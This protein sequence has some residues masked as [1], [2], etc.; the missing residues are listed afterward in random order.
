MNYE[1]GVKLRR[2]RW[3]FFLEKFYWNYGKSLMSDFVELIMLSA[4]SGLLVNQINERYGT[5]F[6]TGKAM[7]FGIILYA[8]YWFIGRIAIEKLHIL[9]I[10]N[11]IA[12]EK[13]P[14]LYDKIKRI[15]EEISELKKL[16]EKQNGNQNINT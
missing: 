12:L 10:Q 13:N 11:E 5:N 3:R 6:D 9:Q 16:R 15:D 14:A 4:S 7:I 1:F 2:L 8:A